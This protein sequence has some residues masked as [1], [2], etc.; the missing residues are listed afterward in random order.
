MLARRENRLRDG[1][2]VDRARGDDHGVEV[3]ARDQLVVRA[4]VD[5]ELR[6]HLPCAP[7]AGGRDGDKR[8]PSVPR[9]HHAHAAEACDAEPDGIA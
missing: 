6:R 5:A 7:G 3:V 9:V 2:V 4:R 1:G 8:V